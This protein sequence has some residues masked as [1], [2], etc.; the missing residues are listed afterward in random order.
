LQAQSALPRQR[1]S[2]EVQRGM[3]PGVEVEGS[4]IVHDPSTIMHAMTMTATSIVH[5]RRLI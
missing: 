4:R 1:I 5:F 3:S 2:P